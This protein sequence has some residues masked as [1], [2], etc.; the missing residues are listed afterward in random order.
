MAAPKPPRL[1]SGAGPDANP[2]ACCDSTR[3]QADQTRTNGGKTLRS[4][5]L[6]AV[7]ANCLRSREPLGHGWAR[8]RDRKRGTHGQTWMPVGHEQHIRICT[9][10]REGDDRSSELVVSSS[11]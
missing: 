4:A 8:Y 11:A 3:A 1:S 10:S 5:Q 6:V 7:M 9:L 2:R